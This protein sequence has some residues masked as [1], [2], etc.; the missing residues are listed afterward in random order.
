[1]DARCFQHAGTNT[2]SLLY[3]QTAGDPAEMDLLSKLASWTLELV[4]DETVQARVSAFV[5]AR[6]EQITVR[7][8]EFFL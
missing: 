3:T 6:A 2:H 4:D 1:M 5:R 7:S 8:A